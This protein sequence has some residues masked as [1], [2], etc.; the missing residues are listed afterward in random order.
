[1]AKEKNILDEIVESKKAEIE[2]LPPFEF[3]VKE[4]EGLSP[5][6]GFFEA[7]DKTKTPSLI[8]EVKKASPS[9]GVFRED[10]DHKIIAKDYEAGGATCLSVL[11]D[12]KYFQGSLKNLEEISKESKLPCLRKDFI[13]DTRQI[14][15]ARLAGADAILLIAA[16]LDDHDLHRFYDVAIDIGMDV[17]V[18][19]HNEEELKRVLDTP[20]R[21]I[22]IN[23]RNLKTFETSLETS[24]KLVEKY[25]SLLESRIIISES[26]IH[27]KEDLD[28]LYEKG[29]RGFLVGESLI[30]QDCQK[31]AVKSLLAN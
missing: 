17:L 7:L 6:K 19:V 4:L 10:F 25:G 20:A 11:T 21:I 24:M 23:N 22:G 28:S 2:S 18:E 9:K 3:F 15:E 12:E 1:M 14:V 13:I 27:T 16:I 5:C 8:A 31:E 29:I 26:G 30:K